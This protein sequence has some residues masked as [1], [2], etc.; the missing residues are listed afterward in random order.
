MYYMD[1][2]YSSNYS[3]FIFIFLFENKFNYNIFY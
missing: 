3:E 2:N 1:F